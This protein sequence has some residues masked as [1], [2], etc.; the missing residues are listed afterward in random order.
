MALT[1]E[2]IA[3]QLHILY[4]M[5]FF[6]VFFFSHF[7]LFGVIVLRFLVS[8]YYTIC[9]FSLM[10][11]FVEWEYYKWISHL[12]SIA[13]VHIIMCEIVLRSCWHWQCANKIRQISFLGKIVQRSLDLSEKL[14]SRYAPANT[15]G[16]KLQIIAK[17]WVIHPPG[18]LVFMQYK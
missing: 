2:V 17:L 5:N 3:F 13:M 6:C 14:R 10:I 9:N 7:R 12:F 11:C 15:N 8:V 18:S 16:A 1:Q 4:P